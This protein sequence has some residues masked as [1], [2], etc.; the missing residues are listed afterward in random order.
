VH[1]KQEKQ[2]F[3]LLPTPTPIPSAGNDWQRG[4]AFRAGRVEE[5]YCDA[6]E[7]L[8]RC[9]GLGSRKFTALH[10]FAVEVKQ[11]GNGGTIRER[12]QESGEGCHCWRVA[13][14]IGFL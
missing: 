10:R 6:Q 12:M 2:K 14:S 7:S 3:F 1:D 13:G 5:V 11:R 4:H 8:L 9:A